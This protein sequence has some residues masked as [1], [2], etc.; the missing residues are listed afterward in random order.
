MKEFTGLEII[1][2]LDLLYKQEALI[3][4]YEMTDER[5]YNSY[6]EVIATFCI[7]TFNNTMPILMSHLDNMFKKVYHEKET[8]CITYAPTDTFMVFNKI[9]DCYESCEQVDVYSSILGLIFKMLSAFQSETKIILTECVEP[10]L[11]ILSA[12]TNS[13]L[14]FIA[15]MRTFV[16]RVMNETSAEESTVHSKLNY[17]MLI[18]E[19]AI[20]SNISFQKIQDKV[21]KQIEEEFLTISN[22]QELFLNKFLE[23]LFSKIEE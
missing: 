23:D 16:K 11:E 2:F 17:N 5:Y 19:F 22:Y 6:N 14:K 4:S 18:R 7:R 1:E 21:I 12:I 8:V 9:F 13:N 10:S 15:S 20:I 3:T